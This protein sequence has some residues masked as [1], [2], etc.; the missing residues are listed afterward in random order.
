M[1]QPAPQ[2]IMWFLEFLACSFGYRT[3]NLEIVGRISI[4]RDWTPTRSCQQS[5]GQNFSLVRV[6]K[7]R[8]SAILCEGTISCWLLLE[9]HDCGRYFNLPS[10]TQGLITLSYPW[11]KRSESGSHFW[12]RAWAQKMRGIVAVSKR[13]KNEP[14]NKL[15]PRKSSDQFF[16]NVLLLFYFL[17]FKWNSLPSS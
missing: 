9:K 7:L 17:F 2:S 5:G 15:L 11:A 13:G 1:P 6:L 12:K 3:G 4:T 10:H 8:V 16:E 14:K